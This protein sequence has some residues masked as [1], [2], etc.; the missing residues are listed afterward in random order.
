[1]AAGTA[2]AAGGRDTDLLRSPVRR[3]IVDLLAGLSEVPDPDSGVSPRERGLVAAEVGAAAG[4]HVTTARFHLDQ[5]LEAGMVTASFR[6]EG[7][8]RPRKR[9]ALVAGDRPLEL[10]PGRG[11]AFLAG[12]LAR[13]LARSAGGDPVTPEQAGRDWAAE[14]VGAP[15]EAA[16]TEPDELWR[17]RVAAT[18]EVLRDWGYVPETT[19][20]PGAREAHLELHGCPFGDLAREQ[21][22]VVCGI[23]RGLISGTLETLGERDVSTELEVFVT[24]TLC[25][26]R[27]SVPDRPR[28]P[29]SDV[30]SEGE[31]A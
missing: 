8:G 16:G 13:T 18:G 6:Q 9:Y 2:Q 7:V 20:G 25:R 29:I 5:L 22:D 19:H 17:E 24:P 30:T 10:T 28:E 21:P 3:T 1:M 26:A 15:A 12:L 31:Q 11:Y 14:H 27:V 4:V 23:H